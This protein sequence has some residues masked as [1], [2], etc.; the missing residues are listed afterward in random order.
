MFVHSPIYLLVTK[1]IMQM[2]L[3]GGEPTVFILV[4]ETLMEEKPLG[5]KILATL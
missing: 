4:G 1:S 5:I 2:K 3:C